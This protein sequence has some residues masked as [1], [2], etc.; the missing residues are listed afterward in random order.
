MKKIFSCLLLATTMFATGLR[1]QEPA[2]PRVSADSKNMHVGY[3][4][5]SRRGRTIFGD[6]VPFGQVWRA[7]ANDPTLVTFR[8]NAVFGG[9]PIK[10]G[11]YVLFARPG[12][13]QWEVVLDSKGG[14]WNAAAYE[15]R[16]NEPD[17]L[18]IEVPAEQIASFAER[19]TMIEKL[20]IRLDED[21]L[22]IEWEQTRVRVPVSFK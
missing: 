2:S 14:Q 13:N 8:R 21:A 9:K 1:A 7:G 12:K 19:P 18:R 16:A 22:V 20:R 11:D 6:V 5:P 17:V 4:Q 15:K 3:G 10:K